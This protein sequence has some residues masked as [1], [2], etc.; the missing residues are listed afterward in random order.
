LPPPQDVGKDQPMARGQATPPQKLTWDRRARRKLGSRLVNLRS[1][2][3]RLTSYVA[4]AILLICLSACGL[5]REPLATPR[6]T[7][8]AQVTADQVAQAMDDDTFYATYGQTS[9]LIQGRVAAVDQQ[10][11][12]FIVTLAT[13]VRTKVQCDLGNK[14]PAVR[15]GDTITIRS[16]NPEQDVSRLD[17]AVLI[18]NCTIP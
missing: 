4:G 12:H 2:H 11:N 15:V 18:H 3:V 9:L 1:N 13:G 17:A 14:A 8:V 5:F 10:A 6:P 16:A 7:T